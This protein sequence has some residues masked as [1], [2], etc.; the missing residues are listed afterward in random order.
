MTKKRNWLGM[1]A[2]VLVFGMMVIGCDNG[3]TDNGTNGL[4]TALNGTWIPDRSSN[5]YL[6]SIVFSNG[7]FENINNENKPATKGTYTTND[8]E[9]I[10]NR[11]LIYGEDFSW[12]PNF[13]LESRW[14]SREELK[15]LFEMDDDF[16]T[17]NFILREYTVDYSITDNILTIVWSDES[18]AIYTRQ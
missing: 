12:V 6:Y 8:G 5:P 16:I 3:T 10:F 15:S 9:I 14:Y 4:D 17:D 13:D 7:N 11:T 1:L 18:E 2:V